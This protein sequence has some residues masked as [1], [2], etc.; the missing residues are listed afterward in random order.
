M[1]SQNTLAPRAGALRRSESFPS[2]HRVPFGG[3]LHISEHLLQRIVAHA[4]STY[5]AEC[6][7]LLVGYGDQVQAAEPARNVYALACGD[8]F[9]IDPLD[10]VRIFESARMAGQRIIGCYHSHPEGMARPSSIDR[11]HAREFGGPFGYLVVA[12][13]GDGFW[14]IYSGRIEPD[15]QIVAVELIRNA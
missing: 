7:G 2:S 1:G 14:D 8:R 15:G 3:A 9:Q 13:D 10:H 5:P 6:C 12:I 4:A 11:Q